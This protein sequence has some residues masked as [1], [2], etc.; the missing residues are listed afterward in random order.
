MSPRIVLRLIV[1]VGLLT[2]SVTGPAWAAPLYGVSFATSQ[3]SVLYQ[4]NPLTGQASDP[5]PTGLD[6]VVGIAF[7]SATTLYGLTNA[8]APTNPNALVRIDRTTGSSQ[9]VGSTG[10]SNISEGD[11]AYDG[12]TGSLYGLYH[13]AGGER[14]LFTLN[15]ATG[16]AST[17]PI[18]LS[19]DPSAMAFTAGGTLYVIDTGLA[20]LLTVD[21]TTGATLATLSLS[22]SLG[23]VAGMAIDPQTG[24][25]Y[26]ADGDSGG[27]DHLYTLN[28]A[29]GLLTDIGP[30]GLP[31]GLAGLAFLPEPA[32]LALFASGLMFTRRR[33]RV[34]D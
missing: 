13:L 20:K 24:T 5:K 28:P 9:L 23:A 15:A 11:M 30:T 4:V 18:S 14:K 27:T 26:V 16:A 21:K 1:L 33:G 6:H 10:L 19:G 8:T 7:G 31:D 2:L 12:T 25:F 29:T 22:R 3:G 32:S 34:R 17:L